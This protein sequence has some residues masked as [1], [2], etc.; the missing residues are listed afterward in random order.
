MKKGKLYKLKSSELDLIILM[1]GDGI[2]SKWG[3]YP[4]ISGVV[5]KND[6]Y[7]ALMDIG[8]FSNTWNMNEFE[9]YNDE[10][11]LDNKLWTPPSNNCCRN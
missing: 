3:D 10:I 8:D 11:T 2:K 5:V 4:T 9:E 6:D 1:T 7:M